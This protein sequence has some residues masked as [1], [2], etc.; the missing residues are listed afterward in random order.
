[1]HN[2][3]DIISYEEI[4]SLPSPALKEIAQ[5]LDIKKV[6]NKDEVAFDIWKKL[7]GDKA[8]RESSLNS[9]KGLLLCGS[10]SVFWYRFVKEDV[11]WVRPAIAKALDVDLFSNEVPLDEDADVSIASGARGINEGEYII[12]YRVK[13][14][15][16]RQT[17]STGV[18]F[19]PRI[20]RIP[21]IINE[22]HR[23]LEIRSD[24]RIARIIAMHFEELVQRPE[25]LSQIDIMSLFGNSVEK[26]ADELG[27]RLVDS[28]AHTEYS[29]IELTDGMR[30]TIASI[31]DAVDNYLA[32][33]EDIDGLRNVLDN[34]KVIISEYE[35][36]PILS[37]FMTKIGTLKMGVNNGD[38]RESP[39]YEKLKHL[40]QNR[41]ALICIND[42]LYPSKVYT[43][44][45]G[46]TTKNIVFMSDTT[47]YMINFVRAKIMGRLHAKNK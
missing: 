25:C 41:T 26:I 17:T 4:K 20:V 44:K 6:A 3:F 11:S 37:L 12:I 24:S 23:T 43:I 30:Q 42:I 27:G 22:T 36:K 38:L 14:G 10:R 8:L 28:S 35:H 18:N 1:M 47:E 29:D 13:V 5:N 16:I 19:V 32:G 15:G 9:F 46:I 33:A 39:M 21:V 40:I 34:A 31:F 45:V 2:I 7:E